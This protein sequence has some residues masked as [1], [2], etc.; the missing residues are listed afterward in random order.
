MADS[1]SPFEP[2]SSADDAPM[3]PER[4]KSVLRIFHDAL[5]QPPGKRTAFV[6]ATCQGDDA[7]LEQVVTLLRA[8][9]ADDSLLCTGDGWARRV[10][11]AGSMTGEGIG[12]YRIGDEIGRG[13]MGVVYR[14]KREDLGTTVAV[15]VLRERFP[16]ADRLR[17]FLAEQRLLARLQHPGI[18]RL[19][20]AGAAEDGTPFFVMEFVEGTPITAY[21]SRRGLSVD[22]RVRLFRQ[23]CK[24]VRYAHR[25]LVVHRDLK[26]SNVLVTDAASG[27]LVKLLDFGI[28]KLLAHDS[29]EDGPHTRTG[30]RLLTPAYA[31]PEQVDARPISTSVDVY[32]LGALLYELLADRRPLKVT[33]LPFSE[34]VQ[35]IL[36]DAPPPPSEAASED[37]PGRARLS[38]D[39]DTIC[40]TALHKDP[41]RRY[42]SA[43]GLDDDLGRFLDDRPVAA[44]PVTA[45]YR[46][47]KFLRRNRPAVLAT[48]AVA[49]LIGLLVTFYTVRV[50]DERDRAEQ[51]A[52]LSQSVVAFLV[53]TLDEGDP[54]TAGGDTLTV[55]DVVDRAEARTTDLAHA[56]LVQAKVLDA[57]GR[58]RLL[59]GRVN[60]ADSLYAAGLSLRR[61]VVGDGHPSVA[62]SLRHLAEVRILQGAYAEADSLAARSV[63]L[64]RGEPTAERLF[65]LK[66]LA[67]AA[68]RQGDYPRADSLYQTVIAAANRFESFS[69]ASLADTHQER[70]MALFQ[71]ADYASAASQYQKA[72]GIFRRLYP[73]GHAAIASALT[74]LA[75]IE[76]VRGE[77]DAAVTGYKEAIAMT[78]SIL[79]SRHLNMALIQNNLAVTYH[80]RGETRRAVRLLQANLDLRQDLLGPDHPATGT[81]HDNLGEMLVSLGELE[82]AEPH[83]QAALR[84]RSARLGTD[85]ER[86]V[87]TLANLADLHEERGNL[88]KAEEM[89]RDAL[90]RYRR[91]LEPDHPRIALALVALGDLLRKRGATA[92][93]EST[94]TAALDLRR[95]TGEPAHD[96][97]PRIL[98]S[99]GRLYE[100]EA[101]WK[102]AEATYREAHTIRRS[103]TPEHVSTAVVARNLG[104]VLSRQGR[105][106]EAEAFLL[107]GYARLRDRR[108]PNHA[109]TQTARRY[110]S[111]LYT[112]WDR[113]VRADAFEDS[114]AVVERP[115][116]AAAGEWTP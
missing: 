45:T 102:D 88:K 51:Q 26:P 108:G 75:S 59:H 14:A 110:L 112:A 66:L 30:E 80:L 99:L 70:G 49:L 34:A 36:H 7:L 71:Q 23:V 20:D 77:Y 38:G 47:R 115:L 18:A 57:I 5:A 60:R 98:E 12:P 31:A 15:K 109:S 91:V 89:R 37:A 64:L 100:D 48:A 104:R 97:I 68:Y 94:L 107:H 83:L 33:G 13:G 69:E 25:N 111:D 28:A 29:S 95:G 21:C 35:R 16:S 32:A 101:R 2:A 3:S 8:D 40:L 61:R 92:K 63:A 105:H 76:R 106:A 85:H 53:E 114:L 6:R 52:A 4:W 81:V 73:N 96:G 24:A 84:I 72:V 44:R 41:A 9:E 65:S 17:R 27:P 50:A 22:E 58:V 103:T 79:G 74:N 11:E 67:Q 82:A 1:N 78:R 43:E 56:P 42:S 39:L 46:T 116:P 19:L 55:Y 90:R 62:S 93:A 10:V 54:N 86:T 113:P 87:G